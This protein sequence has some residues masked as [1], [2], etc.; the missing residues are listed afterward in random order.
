[1]K[2]C[3]KCEVDYPAP[4]EDYFHKKHDAADGFQYRCK[5]CV[6]E[7][8]KQHYQE[9]TVYY[10]KKARKHNAEYRKRNLQFMID[11]LK[12]HPC[13]DCGETNPILLD[14]DH[15]N[16]NK[17]ANVSR[18]ISSGSPFEIIKEEIL[19]CEVH[20]ANCHRLKT[21]TQ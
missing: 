21:A 7:F 10:K 16:G 9:R 12:E 2:I 1:M 6:A 17:I 13:V 8:H 19:K 20:C 14:F 11:Y 15:V 3:T 5:T 4:I 18:M